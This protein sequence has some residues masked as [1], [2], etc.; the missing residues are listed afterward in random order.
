MKPNLNGKSMFPFKE[1]RLRGWKDRHRNN[2]VD[3]TEYLRG[4]SVK[5]K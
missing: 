3:K 4:I 2:M 1:E 5:G